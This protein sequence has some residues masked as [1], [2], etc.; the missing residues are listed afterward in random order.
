MTPSL[1]SKALQTFVK[2]YALLLLVT[3]SLVA[4]PALQ[5]QMIY[6]HA[7]KWPLPTSWYTSLEVSNSAVHRRCSIL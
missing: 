2:V 4:S 5:R 1:H 7:V 3:A 6:L